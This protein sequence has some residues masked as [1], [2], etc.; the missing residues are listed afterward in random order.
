MAFQLKGTGGNCNG[1]EWISAEGA[2]T[3]D[4]PAAFKRFLAENGDYQRSVVFHSPGGDPL[5]AMELGQE[6]RRRRHMT[7]VGRTIRDETGYH[8]KTAPGGCYSACAIAFLGGVQRSYTGDSSSP[9]G[10]NRLGF[11][12]VSFS[13]EPI[14]SSTQS[15][16]QSLGYGLSAGQVISGLLV[17][18][19]VQMEIDPRVITV[20]AS[21]APGDMWILSEREAAAFKVT[22]SVRDQPDWGLQVSRGG[23]VLAGPGQMYPDGTY[24]ASLACARGRAGTLQLDLSVSINPEYLKPSHAASF[25]QSIATV[26]APSG[27][28]WGQETALQRSGYRINGN[29]ASVAIFLDTGRSRLCAARASAFSSKLP[30]CGLTF[31]RFCNWAA[32]RW[33]KR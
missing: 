28:P 8:S 1:C 12:Q 24:T 16:M 25:D 20:A 5:A 4:T 30:A 2:I 9:G 26:G 10:G 17:A 32:G 15:R 33:R 7:S 18:Y 22:S 19:A 11:H 29:R 13:A 27:T 23:L 21:T 3:A 31:S 6:I 14:A